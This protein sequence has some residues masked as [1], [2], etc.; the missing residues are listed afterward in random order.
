MGQAPQTSGSTTQSR[1]YIGLGVLLAFCGLAWAWFGPTS[2]VTYGTIEG[3]SVFA[4]LYVIAQAAERVAEWVIDLLSLVDSSPEKK[5][6]EALT[7]VRSANVMIASGASLTDLALRAGTGGGAEGISFDAAAEAART[8]ATEKEEQEEEVKDA[9]RDINFLASGVS[10]AVCALAVNVLNYGLLSH[11][12]A[13]GV[14]GRWDRLFTLLAAAGGTKALH[15]L[16]GRLQ[17]SK[18]AAE[19][20]Q[21]T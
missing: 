18:E 20:S 16:I 19:E 21:Q 3:V 6:T 4:A 10:I 8:A 7:K 14:D 5:K 13:Q 11:V 12:G 15:E 2:D 17:T 1:V 9:R